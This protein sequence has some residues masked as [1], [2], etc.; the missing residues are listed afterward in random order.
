[1]SSSATKCHSYKVMVHRC[2][3]IVASNRFAVELRESEDA[4]REWISDN[5]VYVDVQDPLWM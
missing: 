4:D 5:M 2:R 3:L 1:M